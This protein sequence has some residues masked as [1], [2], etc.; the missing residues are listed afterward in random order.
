[1]SA[2]QSCCA[3]VRTDM[4][5]AIDGDVARQQLSSAAASSS[6]K[7]SAAVLMSS[8]PPRG[9]KPLRTGPNA[10][11]FHRI[12]SRHRASYHPNISMHAC[13]HIPRDHQRQFV[14]H[15][16]ARMSVATNTNARVTANLPCISKHGMLAFEYGRWFSMCVIYA[17]PIV[18]CSHGAVIS[19]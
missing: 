11:R 18:F 1:M 6:N 3:Q 15:G 9:F 5:S 16:N 7:Q 10:C 2:T 13:A 8:A 4:L 14:D 12:T 17:R 19:R